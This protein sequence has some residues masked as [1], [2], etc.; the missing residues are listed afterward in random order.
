MTTAVQDSDTESG[1]SELTVTVYT[2]DSPMRQP[3][4]LLSEILSDLWRTRELIWIL[5]VR[6]MKAQF[7]QS[8][9][10]YLWLIV[11]PL[12]TALAWWLLHRSGM[13]NLRTGQ[14]G[15]PGVSSFIVVGTTLWGAFSAAL[16]TPLDAMGEGKAVFTRLNVPIESFIISA[17]GR[18]CFNLVVSSAVLLILVLLLGVRPGLTLFVYPFAAT[19]I[20]VMGFSI[21]LLLVPLGALYTDVR[22][23]LTSMVGLLMFTVPVIFQVPEE[24]SG[25]AAMVVRSNPLTPA[26]ALGRD[27][28]LTGDLRWL[29]PTVFWLL[30]SGVL[31]LVAMVI[32]RIAR[33]HLITR[34]GM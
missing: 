20:L 12:V 3:L 11:P 33:P 5:L 8:A 18:V 30:L 10:G 14:T 7:R 16:V 6:D 22:R 26:F 24:G 23:A 17:V 9:L 13:I 29:G 34:M 31:S 25:L 1:Q 19:A 27:A 28:L 32:L 21:G 2:P 4:H 15:A